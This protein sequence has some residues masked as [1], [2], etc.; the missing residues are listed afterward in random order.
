MTRYAHYF[1]A[2]RDQDDGTLHLDC[3]YVVD[4]EDIQRIQGVRA[5]S[6]NEGDFLRNHQDLHE[7][8]AQITLSLN[9]MSLRCR[10]QG[11]IMFGNVMCIRDN[12]R[13][14]HDDFESLI[15]SMTPQRLKEFCV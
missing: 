1:T 2:I 8:E 14:S 10:T 4:M 7:L 9:G 3:F 15:R 13:W 12:A 6:A 11:N 5:L